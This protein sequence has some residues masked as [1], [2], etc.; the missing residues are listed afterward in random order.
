MS[1]EDTLNTSDNNWTYPGGDD[2]LELWHVVNYCVDSC[3]IGDS[4]E[5]NTEN[6]EDESDRVGGAES[7]GVGEDQDE[8]VPSGLAEVLAGDGALNVRN[9]TYLNVCV[10]RDELDKSLKTI[11]TA[12]GAA[13]QGL[14]N[15]VLWIS[16]LEFLSVVLEDDSDHLK[17]GN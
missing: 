12:S 7:E 6:R 5:Q 4:D 1:E 17:D 11:E 15:W 2:A 13:Q 10:D 3:S 9:Q 14:D 8:G 16:R